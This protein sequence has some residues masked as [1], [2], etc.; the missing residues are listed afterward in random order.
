MFNLKSEYFL[1]VPNQFE[2]RMYLILD[3]ENIKYIPQYELNGKYYDAYLPD[4][5]ILLEFDGD[6]WHKSSL[7]EC[8]YKVQ[9]RNYKNDRYKDSLAKNKGYKL[10]RVK[11]SEYITSIKKLLE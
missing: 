10:I 8:R 11:R 2:K 1:K 7:S 3:T 5:N 9:K 4:Y 6:F